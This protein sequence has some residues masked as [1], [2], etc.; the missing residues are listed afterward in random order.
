MGVTYPGMKELTKMSV[1]ECAVESKICGHDN[2]GSHDLVGAGGIYA[3][4][5]SY[6]VDK[7][8]S[9]YGPLENLETS[10]IAKPRKGTRKLS[11]VAGPVVIPVVSTPYHAGAGLNC[12]DEEENN[13]YE[14]KDEECKRN[15]AILL[16]VILCWNAL[17]IGLLFLVLLRWW[18]VGRVPRLCFLIGRR[19]L[20]VYCS[21][22][23]PRIC[24][25]VRPR[26]FCLLLR[27][28]AIGTIIQLTGTTLP[29]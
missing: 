16:R 24:P 22:C 23:E 4:H 13:S 3:T 12:V 25:L 10:E 7:L 15:D 2:V 28:L 9:H 14:E 18:R 8:N 21:R 19:K 6:Y 29:G 1:S 17:I 5:A 26:P 27:P 20:R 11:V